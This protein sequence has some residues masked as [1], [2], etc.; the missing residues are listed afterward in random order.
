MVDRNRAIVGIGRLA[1]AS[2]FCFRSC[3]D[4]SRILVSTILPPACLEL[5]DRN[6]TRDLHP[7]SGPD[8]GLGK[9]TKFSLLLVGWSTA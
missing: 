3:S 9:T 2:F 8:L 5:A 6:L 1:Q 4:R 7:E